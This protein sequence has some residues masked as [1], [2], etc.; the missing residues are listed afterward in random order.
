MRSAFTAFLLTLACASTLPAAEPL[1]AGW[2]FLTPDKTPIAAVCHEQ[3]DGSVLV[4]GKPIGYLQSPA[5][6]RNFRLHVEW[7]W[8]DKP[9]NG[10]VLVGI[11]GGPVDRNTWPRC[12]QIQLKHTRAGDL[13]PM[14]GATFAEKLSTPPDA[15]TP[16]LDHT[17]PDSE[18]PAGEWN[19]CDLV[20]HDGTL[21]VT[22]N[23]VL[24]NHVTHS[25]PVAGHIGLQ[26]EGVPYVIRNIRFEPIAP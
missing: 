20:S 3:P 10:G 22:I 8:P 1:L 17:A 16:Q 26:L 23:G 4:D 25:D 7:R 14:A 19:T 12:L 9:G 15:K 2:A 11:V 13:L 5:A 18:K 21:D 6:G 24:Q